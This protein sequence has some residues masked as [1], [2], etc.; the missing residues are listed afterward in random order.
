MTRP[1]RG[2]LIASPSTWDEC[3]FAVPA[4]RA[5]AASGL[6]VGV[7]CRSEQVP[8]WQSVSGIEVITTIDGDPWQAALLWE[9]GPHAK[10]VAKARI[11]RRLGPKVGKLPKRL[12]HPLT[13]APHPTEHRVQFYL[14]AAAEMGVNT[15]KPEFFS[16]LESPTAAAEPK[17]L[18]VPDSDY[19][20]SHEWLLDRWLELGHA[21]AEMPCTW[22]VGHL[23]QDKSRGL[24]AAICAIFKDDIDVLEIDLRQ[25]D[26]ASLAAYPL[27]IAADGSLPH[28]AAHLGATC[29]T[30]FGANDPAWKRP[31][32]KRHRVLH[33][34]VE[35]APCLL[36]KCPLDLRCQKELASTTVITAA[37]AL[38][39]SI[40]A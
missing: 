30:L 28:L 27:V 1:A 20:P 17:V 31:L 2:L 23:R 18:L 12:T 22:T 35:C 13:D 4:V 39:A 14:K 34:H 33:Q 21:L 25:P 37:R 36:P 9:D 7:L 6:G 26:L 24:D 8:F 38:L 15:S 32:G 10:T 29:L 11:E 3:C 40:R 19:G 5:L 16:P